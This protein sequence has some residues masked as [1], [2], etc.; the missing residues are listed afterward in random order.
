M[1]AAQQS[2]MPTLQSYAVHLKELSVH[3]LVLKLEQDSELKGVALLKQHL[4]NAKTLSVDDFIL[5]FEKD[6]KTDFKLK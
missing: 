5:A 1:L 2:T 6:H 4:A 3:D